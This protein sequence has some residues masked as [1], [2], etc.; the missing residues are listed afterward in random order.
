MSKQADVYI[1]ILALVVKGNCGQVKKL[2]FARNLT[3]GNK[4]AYNNIYSALFKI[5][6]NVKIY[7]KYILSA[8]DRIY[9]YSI[10]RLNINK[11]IYIELENRGECAFLIFVALY[12]VTPE[13]KNSINY[14]RETLFALFP[15]VTLSAYEIRVAFFLYE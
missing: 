2:A 4:V 15:R 10:Y 5:T 1:L 7:T 11:Y 9:I 12:V 8:L 3:D 6:I 14:H 13:V